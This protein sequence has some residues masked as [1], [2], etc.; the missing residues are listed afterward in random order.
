MRIRRDSE[1]VSRRLLVSGVSTGLEVRSDEIVPLFETGQ[2]VT[3]LATGVRGSRLGL[4]LSA[5]R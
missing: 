5:R 1:D 4:R 3:G 2:S